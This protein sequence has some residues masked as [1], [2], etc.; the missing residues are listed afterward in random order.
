MIEQE[1]KMSEN[2]QQP[3]YNDFFAY[4]NRMKAELA[5]VDVK[6]SENDDGDACA[7]YREKL[8]IYQRYTDDLISKGFQYLDVIEHLK[9]E[10]ATNDASSVSS[11][12]SVCEETVC[13]DINFIRKCLESRTGMEEKAFDSLIQGKRQHFTKSITFLSNLICFHFVLFCFSFE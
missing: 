2:S 5:S 7:K 10:L 6:Y 1:K 13:A 11:S 4:V 8:H 3:I 9:K 12:S